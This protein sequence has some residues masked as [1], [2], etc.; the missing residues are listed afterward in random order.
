MRSLF[1]AL[2]AA[3]VLSFV[4]GASVQERATA[5]GAGVPAVDAKAQGGCGAC[6]QHSAPESVSTR[7]VP[8]TSETMPVGRIENLMP[9]GVLAALGC[10]KCAGEA[11]AWAVE[12]GSSTEDVER[13]LRTLAAMQTLDCFKQQFGADAAARFEKPLAAARK[14]LQQAID[15]ADRAGR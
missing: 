4:Q 11:V 15:R 9:I 5:P 1:L 3:G 12:Q 14:V 10:E 8:G 7:P 2:V 13:A 6:A